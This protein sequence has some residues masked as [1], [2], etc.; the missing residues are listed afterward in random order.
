MTKQAAIAKLEKRMWRWQ[1]KLAAAEADKW[2]PGIQEAQEEIYWCE[3]ELAK[4]RNV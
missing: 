3:E 1:D 2:E 4:W